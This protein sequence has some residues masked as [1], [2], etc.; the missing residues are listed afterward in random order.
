MSKVSNVWVFSDS[1][2]RLPEV[3]AGGLQLGE[4]VSVF[5][6]GSEEAVTLA[7]ALGAEKVYF[8]EKEESRLIESYADTMAA[9]IAGEGGRSLIMMPGTR[10]CKG[11]AS[12]LG[13]RLGAGVMT[14]VSELSSEDGK[15]HGKRMVL[16]GLAI[17]AERVQSAVSIAVIAGG[18]YSPAEPDTSRTGEAVKL[19]YIEPAVSVRCTERRPREG[20]RVDLARARRV[21][22]I[23]RGIAR[24]EDIAMVEDFCS[25]IDAELGCSRPIAEG[26][27]WMEHER[28][29]GISGVMPK[30]DL[31]MALG[32]SGQIQHMVGANGS[33]SIVA[34]NKDKNAPIFQYA[35]YGIV[36]D[37]YKVVPALVKAFKS[38]QD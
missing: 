33:Q 34:V 8:I 30:P 21:V 35:D 3:I 26:E 16:G 29:I 15:V 24:Q 2:S 6:V 22:G 27:K 9:V 28:Y 23:G 14:D 36:G 1:D 5:V 13:V 18:T 37:L 38:N 11:L 10:C 20:S 25:V 31:Y 19:D 32:I 4:K 17:G 7:Y 12:L